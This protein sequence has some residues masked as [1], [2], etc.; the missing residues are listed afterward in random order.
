MIRD[1][2]TE[3]DYHFMAIA[4]LYNEC[5]TRIIHTFSLTIYLEYLSKILLLV[6]FQI[7]FGLFDFLAHCEYCNN[8]FVKLIQFKKKIFFSML[9]HTR[10]GERFRSSYKPLLK[11]IKYFLEIMLEY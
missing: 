7:K 5:S 6:S 1:I 11:M 2:V 9:H 3:E 8:F 10:A 4:S